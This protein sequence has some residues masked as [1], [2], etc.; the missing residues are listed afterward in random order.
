[1]SP[2]LGAKKL[3]V[4]FIAGEL[5]ALQEEGIEDEELLLSFVEGRENGVLLAVFEQRNDDEILLAV[6][7]ECVVK[8]VRFSFV[9]FAEGISEGVC[10]GVVRGAVCGVVRGAVRGVTS[11]EVHFEAFV[12]DVDSSTFFSDSLT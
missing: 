2:T 6:I 12:D 1:M 3:V 8:C 4:A 11:S 10:S 9:V 7:L 5:L